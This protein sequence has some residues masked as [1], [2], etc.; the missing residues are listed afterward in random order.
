MA[1]GIK[2]QIPNEEELFIF[3]SVIILI[4]RVRSIFSY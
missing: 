4:L 3:F 2:G 1:N